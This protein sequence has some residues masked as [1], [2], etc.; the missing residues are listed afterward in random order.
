M[1]AMRSA[2]IWCPYPSR[3]NSLV[4]VP[5]VEQRLHE[6]ALAAGLLT[7]PAIEKRFRQARFGE[8]AAY[9][10]PDAPDLLVYAKWLTWLFVADDEFD[11]NRAPAEG[12]ID[13][14]VLGLLPLDGAAPVAARTP[15]TAA[16]AELWR[17]LAAT[18]PRPLQERF[19]R[20]A[21]EY[22][23]SYASDLAR[24][25]TGAVPDLRAY[26]ELRRLSGAVETCLDL[27]ERQP[28]A[29]LYPKLAADPA[30]RAVRLA[31]NDIICWSNDVFS[32]AK[33]FRHGELNNLV[34]VLH[35]ASGMTWRGA[36]ETAADMT[37]ART[38]EFDDL[39]DRLL[40]EQGTPALRQF[41][42]G[43]KAWISGSLDWHRSSPRYA[44]S[45]L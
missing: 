23:R 27:I 29:Y 35:G 43:L 42:A 3:R 25:R 34:T 7:E 15:V 40:A 20:N 31:A 19:R 8:C 39:Q 9:S 44:D 5:E 33:E 10:Y 4:S 1:T 18:M 21:D 38:R 16:L 13:R 12:G 41:V 17:E 11:E 45:L 2:T 36:V 32:V 6:W 37:S 28:E 30:T 24:D 26:I 22:A 14:G